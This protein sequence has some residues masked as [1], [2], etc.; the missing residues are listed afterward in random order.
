MP[1][2][3][4]KNT[5]AGQFDTTVNYC[6]YLNSKARYSWNLTD[7]ISVEDISDYYAQKTHGMPVLHLAFQDEKPLTAMFISPE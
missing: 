5:L 4:K 3:A 7:E 1:P 2:A 6:L